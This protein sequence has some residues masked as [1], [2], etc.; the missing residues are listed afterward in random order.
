MDRFG[1]SDV[2]HVAVVAKAA[3]VYLVLPRVQPLYSCKPTVHKTVFSRIFRSASDSVS[4]EFRVTSWRDPVVHPVCTY[5][6][7]RRVEH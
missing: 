5:R 7:S 1:N 2:V 3:A 6:A 4:E